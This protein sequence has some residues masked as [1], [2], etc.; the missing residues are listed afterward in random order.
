MSPLS[1]SSR[2]IPNSNINN[3]VAVNRVVQCG[4]CMLLEQEIK[5]P[6]TCQTGTTLGN[7]LIKAYF[8]TQADLSATRLETG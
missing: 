4:A 5:Q 8:K 1:P 2:V 7:S 6:M 3:T